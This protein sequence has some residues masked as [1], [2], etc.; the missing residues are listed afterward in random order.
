MS[1][2]GQI[3]RISGPVV[4]AIG[5]KAAMLDVVRV[6]DEG[7]MGEVIEFGYQNIK[8]EDLHALAEYLL[9]LEPISNE[10]KNDLSN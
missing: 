4:T 7:L 3:Y 1:K 6:G 10:L 9:S 8:D 2:K 5:I